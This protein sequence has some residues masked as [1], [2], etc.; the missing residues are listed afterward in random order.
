MS[1]YTFRKELVGSYESGGRFIALRLLASY[2]MASGGCDVHR[3]L[4]VVGAEP[5]AGSYVG[6]AYADGGTIRAYT[7]ERSGETLWFDD[8]VPSHT[9][10]WRSARKL[11]KPTREGFDERLEVDAGRGFIPYC[12][13]SMRRLAVR[14]DGEDHVGTKR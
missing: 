5:T 11:L 2:P 7:V 8:V 6:H 13:V 1:R 4:V 12:S 3:A 10:A 9:P 14:D